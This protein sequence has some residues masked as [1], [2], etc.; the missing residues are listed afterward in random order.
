M[1]VVEPP[2]Y[3][4]SRRIKKNSIAKP[5][6]T[7]P[8]DPREKWVTIIPFIGALVGLV[9]AGLLVW[10][11]WRSVINHKYCL[12]FEDDFSH[13]LNS[14]V[15]HAEIQLGNFGYAVIDRSL[16]TARFPICETMS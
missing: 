11:G 12:V 13:G 2:K 3:F 16:F 14:D 5:W 7:E 10:D 9:L 4:H 6:L 8:P 15:W 1:D